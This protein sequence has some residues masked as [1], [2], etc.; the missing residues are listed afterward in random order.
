MKKL[1]KF[2]FPSLVLLSGC[3]N[4]NTSSS[5]SQN[6]SSPLNNSSSIDVIETIIT[7]DELD[8]IAK[9][10]KE[11]NSKPTF[12]IP[13]KITSKKTIQD[14]IFYNDE[15]EPSENYTYT[16]VMGIDSDLGYAYMTR[17]DNNE[18]SSAYAYVKDTTFIYTEDYQNNK[19]YQI[20]EFE[21]KEMALQYF[22][23]E[24]TYMTNFLDLI[25]PD[26][27]GLESLKTLTSYIHTYK[28]CE[29]NGGLSAFETYE[30]NI[31]GSKTNENSFKSHI[32]V[33]AIHENKLNTFLSDETYNFEFKNG[34]QTYCLTDSSIKTTRKQNNEIIITKSKTEII[35]TLDVNIIYPDLSS[36]KYVDSLF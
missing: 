33:Y 3:V 9:N 18:K 32:D 2:L 30:L 12:K 23:N 19:Q 31:E 4:L 16:T 34:I 8:T 29:E 35:N 6:S 10:I 28:V 5:N 11:E 13:S 24:F 26:I 22:K 7:I 15:Q 14:K 21:S 1:I 36:Y 25:T 20:K 17:D 27:Q